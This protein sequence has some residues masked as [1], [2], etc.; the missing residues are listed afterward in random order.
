MPDPFHDHL[1]AAAHAARGYTPDE[2]AAAARVCRMAS[3]H[4]IRTHN[5]IK[6]LHL[7]DHFGSG[8][9][10]CVPGAKIEKLPTRYKAVEKWNA[11]K[12]LGMAV[13]F[14]AMETC[15]KLADEFGIHYLWGGGYVIDAADKGYIAYTCCT[16]ALAEVAPFGGKFPTLGTNPHSWGFPT[17]GMIGFPI[18]IDWATSTVAMG[19]VQQFVREGKKLPPGAAVDID[20]NETT[21]PT[22]VYALVPFGQHKGYGMS[23]IDEILAAFIGGSLPTLR[24]RANQGD[25]AEK[26]TPSFYFQCIRPD[27][28]SGDFAMG[29]TQAKNVKA[30][31]DDIVGH[32]NEKCMLPGQMEAEAAAASDRSGGL[33]FTTAEMD[34]FK[35]VADQLKIPFDLKN[36]KQVEA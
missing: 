24:C 17:R 21:D 23:L 36:F 9:G 14:E 7:D 33:L 8:G 19:R 15:M 3:R 16:A 11:H 20:G 22:K 18:C 32:G 28:I 5:G 1:V 30:V 35:T 29:R 27:A 34:A 13:A 25:P 2:S 4:G 10:G 26:R 31:I 12:K 6:A